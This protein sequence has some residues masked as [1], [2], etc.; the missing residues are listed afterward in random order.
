MRELQLREPHV[1]EVDEWKRKVQ[2]Y[3]GVREMEAMMQSARDLLSGKA[4]QIQSRVRGQ[5]AIEAGI[6]PERVQ[7]IGLRIVIQ[8]PVETVAKIS[9]A[10]PAVLRYCDIACRRHSGRSCRAHQSSFHTHSSL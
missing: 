6:T 3:E 10:I 4:L 1:G 7:R 5:A 9:T 2:D 8:S